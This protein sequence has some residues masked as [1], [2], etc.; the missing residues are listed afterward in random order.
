MRPDI[1]TR[2]FIE[3][4]T[5][6]IRER[7]LPEHALIEGQNELGKKFGVSYTT[8]RKGLKTLIDQKII[9]RVK[10]KGTFVAP[11]EHLSLRNYFL[12]LVSP[13]VKNLLP[14]VWWRLLTELR[15]EALNRGYFLSVFAAQ[16]DFAEVRKMCYEDQIRGAFL[17]DVPTEA[18]SIGELE[19]FLKKRG[20]PVIRIEERPGEKNADTISMDHR[21]AGRLTAVHLASR[22][23]KQIAFVSDKTAGIF[24]Q[25]IKGF[26]E[27]AAE[28][29]L[30][31]EIIHFS[32]LRLL[33]EK[34][35][36]RFTGMAFSYEGLAFTC[37][38][39]CRRFKIGIPK[40]LALVSIDGSPLCLKSRPTLSSI[41]Q[42][43]P[44]MAATAMEKMLLMTRP[45][46]PLKTFPLV[47]VL[48]FEER[49]ASS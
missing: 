21:A 29:G 10:G 9:Y 38:E 8:V 4:L 32:Q 49:R 27:G 47:R 16:G 22:G 11:R 7:N 1:L 5:R 30:K 13:G 42:P 43:L 46:K 48:P 14:D 39:L 2:K 36:R 28:C 12:V 18:S 23:R 17:I 44:E 3:D 19:G 26:L 20:L 6:S 25:R 35:F 37:L 33:D 40:D 24:A 45:E 34:T 41:T 31:G 15:G